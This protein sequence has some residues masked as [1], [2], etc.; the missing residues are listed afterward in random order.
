MPS[1]SPAIMEHA[2]MAHEPSGVLDIRQLQ[3]SSATEFYLT[4]TSGPGAIRRQADVMYARIARAVHVAGAAIVEERLFAS[5]DALPGCLAARALAYGPLED[6]VAPTLLAPQ[7][8]DAR[9][10]GAQVHAIRGIGEPVVLTHDRT[11]WARAFQYDGYRYLTASGLRN[12]QLG[13][14]PAQTRW[15]FEAAEDLLTQAGGKVADIARTWIWMDD[16]LAWYPG[17]NQARTAFFTERCLMDVPGRMPASTGIGVSPA[18][19]R[20]AL[21]LFAA[22]GKDDAVTRF[23]AAG[24]QRSAYE[25]GSAF[26]RASRARTPCG[27]TVFCSGTA[28]IDAR[29][30]SC[31]P[32]DPAGQIDMTIQNVLAVLRDMGCSPE[33]VVQAMAYCATPQTEAAFLATHARR[34]PWP[35]L[36]MP[37][38]VCRAD[39]LFEVEVTACPRS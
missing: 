38:D 16:I 1:A 11:P 28:A 15:A 27:V 32:S 9:I 30:R 36:T 4:A 25:Y 29:G 5:A 31:F 7:S 6:G 22:W 13:G 10:F 18:G 37:G 35:W 3:S 2:E 24:N 34:L 39:L 33:D 20:L 14:G 17:L 23:H 8:Q 12:A 21:D 19:A 26:A